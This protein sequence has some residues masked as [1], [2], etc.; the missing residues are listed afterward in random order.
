MARLGSL[1]LLLACLV[2]AAPVAAA[3]RLSIRGRGWGHGVGMSQWGA[4]GFAKNGTGYRDI[5]SHYYTGT[6]LGQTPNSTV[7]VLLASS[8]GSIAFTGARK[9]ATRRLVPSRTYRVRRGG[10]TSVVLLS[11]RGR[12]LGTYPAPLR[13]VARKGSLLSL[14][15]DEYRGAFEVHPGL[16]GGVNLVNALGLESYIRGVVPRESPASWPVEALK[17]QAVAARTYAITTSRSGQF[18]HYPDTRSQVYGG[19]ASEV[20]STDAAIRATAG[21]VV[22]YDGEPVVT[23]FFSTSGGRTEDV[24]NT[25][26]GQEPRPWL[27]S[28]ED[29]YDH[30]SPKHKWGPLRMSLRTADR[31]LGSLVKGS[32]KGI[33]VVRRGESPRVVIADILGSDGRTRTTGGVLR[34]RFGLNDTWAYFT[35]ISAD[36]EDPPVDEE[37]PPR[38]AAGDPSGGTS[39]GGGRIASVPAIGVLKGYVRPGRRGREYPV[40]ARRGKRWVKVG[41]VALG[42]RGR[43]SWTV[44]A[45]GVYR[46]GPDGPPVRFRAQR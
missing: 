14:G 21:E 33:D 39:A 42:E 43:Y 35:V 22:T 11:A 20:A 31:K 12:R 19:V 44:R 23:F 24:E 32:F 13:I 10:A 40:Q 16:L 37:Q 6:K 41:V 30:F 9:A 17:A 27:K 5:L 26:L 45:A 38:P 1:I 4:Y 3:E 29:P 25:P 28:V 8:N 7:R 18:D 36:D 15:A 34:A 2:A 46:I